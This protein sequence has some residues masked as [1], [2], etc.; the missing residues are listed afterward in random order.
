VNTALGHHAEGRRYNARR[1]DSQSYSS[2]PTT[3]RND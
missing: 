3:Q 1:A 2:D